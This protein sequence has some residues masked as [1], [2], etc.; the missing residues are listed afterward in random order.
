MRWRVCAPIPFLITFAV[1]PFA[2]VAI[3]LAQSSVTSDSSQ[4]G[5]IITKLSEPIYPTIA[6]VA[7]VSGDVHLMLGIFRNGSIESA[8][9]VDGPPIL[10]KAALESAQKSQFECKGCGA[11]VTPYSL[12]YTFQLSENGQLQSQ[13]IQ[14]QNHVTVIDQ[15]VCLCD[16]SPDRIKVRSAKCLYLW[17]CGSR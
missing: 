2:A 1:L 8:V 12:T 9:V 3:C 11:A 7:R 13:V 14:S 10:H 15:T 16:P 4:N 6:R 17:R 5:V